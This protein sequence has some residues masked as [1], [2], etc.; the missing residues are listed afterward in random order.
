LTRTAGRQGVEEEEITHDRDWPLYSMRSKVLL[1]GSLYVASLILLSY[2]SGPGIAPL[3][4]A[5]SPS[6][7]SMDKLLLM[8]IGDHSYVIWARVNPS[9]QYAE[10]SGYSWREGQKGIPISTSMGRIGGWVEGDLRITGPTIFWIKAGTPGKG[11]EWKLSPCCLLPGERFSI[12]FDVV[13]TTFSDSKTSRTTVNATTRG[14]RKILEALLHREV[15]YG[16]SRMPPME[17]WVEMTDMGGGRFSASWKDPSVDRF[18]R[19]VITG[20]TASGDILVSRPRFLLIGDPGNLSV[21]SPPS[22]EE[23]LFLDEPVPILRLLNLTMMLLFLPITLWLWILGRQPWVREHRVTSI[24][25]RVARRGLAQT[26]FFAALSLF[27]YSFV[28]GIA[29]VLGSAALVVSAPR[30]PLLPFLHPG[31]LQ[32]RLQLIIV[33]ALVYLDLFT[34]IPSK[35]GLS[36]YIWLMRG[37]GRI[38]A[39]PRI[40]R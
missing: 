8:N 23:F 5:R 19:Y 39:I 3:L 40:V 33:L 35:A 11:S 12:D 21:D 4:G 30:S 13:N 16:Y 17:G 38:A 37:L 36:L 31:G 1:L 24:A 14:D 26:V 22:G 6:R 27:V 28:I 18:V 34:K 2:A 9:Y 32:W 10:I 15:W 20:P 7:D 25:S 29:F